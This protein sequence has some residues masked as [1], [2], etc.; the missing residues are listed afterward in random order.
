VAH[1][2]IRSVVPGQDYVKIAHGRYEKII[3]TWGVD[4]QGR[5]NK[6]SEGGFGVVTES[7]R[8]VS[9]WSALAYVDP[10]T[11]QREKR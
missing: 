9:M 2:D 10:E 7:G 4:S 8:S 11:A 3:S 5:L 1:K 6:P